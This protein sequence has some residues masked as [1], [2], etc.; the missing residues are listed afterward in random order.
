[1]STRRT[2][3]K[4]KASNDAPGLPPPAPR[5]PDRTL[6]DDPASRRRDISNIYINDIGAN[7][8]ASQLE[9]F[10]SYRDEQDQQLARKGAE[11]FVAGLKE[12]VQ[13]RDAIENMLMMQMAWTHA[14]LAK[15]S[16]IAHNQ[17]ETNNVRIVNEACDRAASTF[18]RQML[19][20]SEYRR[21]PRSDAFYAI[22]QANVANQ[23][24]V[25][26]GS[27]PIPQ[28]ENRSNEL[29]SSPLPPDAPRPCRP[30]AVGPDAHPMG[31]EHRPKDAGGKAAIQ[32]E[33]PEAR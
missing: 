23:Q 22:R 31:L 32:H 29:G 30:A 20:L 17:K 15:L 3:A 19:T 25:A 16:A 11:T 9:S 24:V 26:N 13:P 28:H 7:I 5:P 21:P 1:M 27:D 6:P 33:R 4:P 2:T 18:R 12:S 10:V 8:I 14:R